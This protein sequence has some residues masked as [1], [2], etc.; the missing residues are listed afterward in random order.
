MQKASL[1]E[2]VF[3]SAKALWQALPILAGVLLL[4]SLANTL[5]P[6]Q[7][8]AYLFFK[9]SL[10]DSFI[11]SAVGSVLAGS[12]I[13]SYIIGG[14]LL[15]QGISMTAVTAF[16]VAWVTVGIVQLPAEAMLLGKKFAITRN[17]CAFV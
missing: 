17:I 10:L 12:P 2:A 9:N 13:T 16:I 14:E 11:G 5:I 4:V 8:Y 1:K 6:K 3:K 7:A 15:A